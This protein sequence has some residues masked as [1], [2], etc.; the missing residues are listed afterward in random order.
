MTTYIVGKPFLR[1]TKRYRRGEDAPDG[2]DKAT[3]AEYLRLGLIAPSETKPAVPR[4]RKPAEPKQPKPAITTSPESSVGEQA[5][6]P[7]AGEEQDQVEQAT[8]D[9]EPAQAEQDASPQ[10]PAGD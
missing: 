4:T 5:Q 7:G 3:E 10:S 8:A 9:A 6:L 2:L 1:G